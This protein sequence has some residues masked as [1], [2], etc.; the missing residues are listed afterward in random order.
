MRKLIVILIATMS[1][2]VLPAIAFAANLKNLDFSAL[3]GD[4]IEIRLG[5]DGAPPKADGYTI[6]QPARIAI[7]LPGAKNALTKK[8]YSLGYGNAQSLT[9]VEAQGRTRLI[10]T[11]SKLVG[12]TMRTEGNTIYVLVGDA[13]SKAEGIPTTSSATASKVT[14]NNDAN[15]GAMTQPAKVAAIQA[16][17]KNASAT[18]GKGVQAIDFKRGDDGAGNVIITLGDPHTAVDVSQSGDSIKV[19]LGKTNLPANLKRKMDVLDFATPVKFVDASREDD[20]TLITIDVVGAYEQMIYQTDNVLTVS[21]KP[22]TEEALE[23]KKRDN[24]QYNGDKLSLN[25]QDIEV[26]SVLQLIADFTGLNLVASD[27]VKGNIT[28]R[29]QNV[30]WDQ[31]LDL[32]LKS[33]GLDK[34]KV[35]NVLMVGPAAE[36]TAREKL[37]IETSKQVAELAPLR[38][39]TI[40]LRY[41]K[42]GDV[43][44]ILGGCHA[45][46]GS[47]A[48]TIGAGASLSGRGSC[49][50]DARTNTIMITD[51]AENLE[52]I[53]RVVSIIDI[54]VRQVLIEARIV[55]ANVS[56]SKELGVDWNLLSSFGSNNTGFVGGSATT[57]N[58][59]LP[60]NL[61][62]NK[63][64]NLGIAGTSGL[65][66]AYFEGDTL[67]GLHLSAMQSDG[68]GEIVSQPRV[69][70]A[71]GKEASISS[72]QEI[73]YSTDSD[74]GTNTEFKQAELSLKVTPQITPD[75]RVIM[76]IE[77]TND[78]VG[79]VVNGE[80]S[81]DTQ[82]VTTQALVKNGE[83]VVL[84]G[85]FK[86]DVGHTI[87][88]VPFLGDVPGIGHLFRN[89]IDTTQK[90][91]LL[92]FITP[93]ILKDDLVIK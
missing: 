21:V 65:T 1:M 29:L 15:N 39:D 44:K 13:Y 7:D 82:S 73:A 93:K 46:T 10:I 51:T 48:K 49:V 89:E 59:N 55:N 3:P 36:I 32:V 90:K 22:T 11:L 80:P 78:Q 23:K 76:D 31:A 79:Q 40:R 87:S 17:S 77:I 72:G 14:P 66:M 18:S 60:G 63:A 84:G 4:K 41:A 81:I 33:K 16:G 19:S 42:A 20:N 70:T 53:R 68:K 47:A 75:D 56:Y 50:T 2:G 8:S 71:D 45:A 12:H 25:F 37:E 74:N 86:T 30:P 52:E 58:S 43:E 38:N 57:L 34:R 9:V 27:T 35:G 64:V 6:E 85:I 88:K 54:P 61:N 5:F 24:F 69:V 28:L 62:I 91:E 83:T 26:R 67:I 92:I